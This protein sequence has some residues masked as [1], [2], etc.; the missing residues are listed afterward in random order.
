VVRVDPA[1]VRAGSVPQGLNLTIV[2]TGFAIGTQVA[3]GDAVLQ[4][5]VI[6]DTTLSVMIPGDKLTGAGLLRIAA[7]GGTPQTRSN[8]LT[9]TV[10]DALTS[11]VGLEP[12]STAAHRSGATGTTAIVVRGTGFDGT[13]TVLFNGT[14]VSTT[15]ESD[16]SLRAAVPNNLLSNPGQ[17]NVVVRRAG[18]LTA[19][20]VF[21]I[22]APT[23]STGGT[24]SCGSRGR[25]SDTGLRT[26][27]CTG[28]F[29]GLRCGSDGCLS[30]DAACPF[31]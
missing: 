30:L 2:G 17:V 9:L 16:T 6:S 14:E 29:P 24:V 25:C 23:G 10:F 13:S 15:F 19:P 21:T 5:A 28:D 8:E 4:G 1:S 12:I 31:F 20:L 27:E 26:G 7:I 11:L 3:V 18:D 22:L